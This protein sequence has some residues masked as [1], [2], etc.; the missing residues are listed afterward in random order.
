MK[1]K[2]NMSP[3]TENNNAPVTDNNHKKYKKCQK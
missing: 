3:P 1:K 2:G